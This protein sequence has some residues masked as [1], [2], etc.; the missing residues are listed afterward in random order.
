MSVMKCF[1]SVRVLPAALILLLALSGCQGLRNKLPTFARG[2]DS[3]A[4]QE[5]PYPSLSGIPSGQTLNGQQSAQIQSDLSATAL[6]AQTTA[7]NLQNQQIITPVPTSP[8]QTIP[9]A[10]SGTS[11]DTSVQ[12]LTTQ[13]RLARARAGLSNSAALASIPQ[14]PPVQTSSLTSQQSPA[15]NGSQIAASG[16]KLAVLYFDNGSSQLTQRDILILRD[17][18]KF[19]Q[20]NGSGKLLIQGHASDDGKTSDEVNLRAS[21]NRARIVGEALI[22]MGVPKDLLQGQAMGAEAQIPGGQDYNRRVD[23]YLR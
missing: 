9:T 11:Y 18:A 22:K 7:T 10:V 1:V 20:Q 13:E 15:D 12:G 2:D 6:R 19:L 4:S 14:T 21:A 8:I 16:K 23:I 17:V 3:A 5:E